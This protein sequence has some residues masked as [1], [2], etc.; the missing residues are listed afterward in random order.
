MGTWKLTVV[1]VLHSHLFQY[2][3]GHTIKLAQ[4]HVV[5]LYH[6]ISQAMSER[7]ES[8]TLPTPAQLVA[9]DEY[10][11]EYIYPAVIA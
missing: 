10:S 9:V 4:C 8:L 3:A 2:A 1:C 7:F 5:Y 6:H 11:I